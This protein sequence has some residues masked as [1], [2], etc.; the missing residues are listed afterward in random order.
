VYSASVPIT[1]PARLYIRATDNDRSPGHSDLDVLNIDYI[2]LEIDGT[3]LA[4]DTILVKS[5]DVTQEGGVDENFYALAS[6]LVLD[7]HQNPIGGVRIDGVF[8]GPTSSSVTGVTSVDGR[9][10]IKSDRN[11]APEG[12]WSFRITNVSAPGLSYDPSL[13]LSLGNQVVVSGIPLTYILSQNYPNPFNPS[14]N[15]NLWLPNRSQT[16]VN[17]YDVT[18]RRVAELYSGD[19]SAGHHV[20]TWDASTYASGV[21]FFKADVGGKS[22]T[23]KATLLK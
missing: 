9:L 15:I 23:K 14:T 10:K 16:T 6:V 1:G 11:G 20:F 17:V 13:S 12:I 8:D 3:P 2:Y 19:L 22:T 7:Q 21:Y 18:G 4:P 5:V